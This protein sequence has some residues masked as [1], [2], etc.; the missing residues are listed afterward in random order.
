MTKLLPGRK[1]M[2][3]LDIMLKSRNITLPTKVHRVKATV[4]PLVMYRCESWIIKKSWAPKNWCFGTVVL[5]KI[6]E[7]LLDSQELKPI[8]SKGNYLWIFVGGNGAESWSS[9]TLST[10]SEELTHW[11]RR[12][13]WERLKVGGE[14]DNRG[15]DGWM[16]SPTRWTWVWVSPRSWWWTGKPGLLQSMGSQRVGHNWATELNW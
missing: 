5:K 14:G 13:F 9:N 16:A 2:T 15:W 4:F 11:K 1:T 3:N 12:W 7:S 10:W 8:N 6:F